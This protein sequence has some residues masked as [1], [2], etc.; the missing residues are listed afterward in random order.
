MT[1][2]AL[3]R[4]LEALLGETATTE[5]I[6]E[7]DI[8]LIDP[9]PHQ[10]RTRYNE[11]RLRELADSI[12]AHGLVQPILVR[13]RGLRYEII[14]G[15]RRWRAAQLAGL[16]KVPA[17]VRDV[18]EEQVLE[19][20]LIE[21]IQREDLNPIEEA[22]AYQRLIEQLGLTQEE[23][24][25][26]VGR[27]RTS[28]AN[29]LRLL[30]L[31]SDIQALIEEGKISFG[32]AKALLG[33]SSSELQKQ[34]AHEIVARGLS[35]R[36]TEALVRRLNAAPPVRARRERAP[37]DPHLRAAAERLSRYLGTKVRIIPGATG[38]KIEIEYYSATDLERLY[39]LILRK[40]DAPS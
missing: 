14:A 20:S 5:Q 23:L 29:S 2:K 31:P 37:L 3:G 35:V 30:R 9:N 4:G 25:R 17:V 21:N 10:P 18:P 8:D 34:L 38:G 12:R 7:L 40:G 19:L 33:L 27:D 16:L 11:D 22:Q 13:R 28:I 39:T 15:E 6:T 26:R 36:E 1:R 32:H 24:A